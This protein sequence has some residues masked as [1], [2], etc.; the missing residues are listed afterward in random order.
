MLGRAPWQ[1]S[2]NAGLY[3]VFRTVNFI[4]FSSF[5]TFQRKKYID[6]DWARTLCRQIMSAVAH[7][8]S[9]GIAHRDI[10]LQNILMDHYL[11][12]TAQVKLI[13]FGYSTR[14]EGEIKCPQVTPDCN[15]LFY[16]IVFTSDL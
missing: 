9:R 10:K 6:E 1:T 3:H 5:N 14:Y 2:I 15:I 11:D 4:T 7:I 8:H 12:R 16:M 13:D